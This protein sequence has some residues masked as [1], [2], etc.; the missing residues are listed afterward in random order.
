MEIMKKLHKILRLSD[1]YPNL[2]YEFLCY[3]KAFFGGGLIILGLFLICCQNM[4][5]GLVSIIFGIWLFWRI[6]LVRDL[7]KLLR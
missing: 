3:V 1:P 5:L 4:F 6:K 7:I 2:T